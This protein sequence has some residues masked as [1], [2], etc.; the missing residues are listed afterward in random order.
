MGLFN[1]LRRFFSSDPGK[2]HDI[3]LDGR[4]NVLSLRP[5]AVRLEFSLATAHELYQK[6]RFAFIVCCSVIILG[7]AFGMYRSVTWANSAV[8]H[9][10]TCLGGWNN[11]QNA[12]GKPDVDASS[13]QSAFTDDNSAV[14]PENASSDIFCGGFIGDIPED[15]QPTKMTLTFSWITKT[16]AASQSNTIIDT[17]SGPIIISTS[18]PDVSYPA[19]D[20]SDASSTIPE[21]ASPSSDTNL[22]SDTNDTSSE[23]PVSPPEE[24]VPPP[25]PSEAAPASDQSNDSPV[26]LL[27]LLT[28]KAFAQEDATA[29]TLDDVITAVTDTDETTTPI[30]ITDATTTVVADDVITATTDTEESA[31]TTATSTPDT[32]AQIGQDF[33]NG[34]LKVSYTLDGNTWQ[35]LGIIDASDLASASFDIPIASG[36]SWKDM[37]SFQ[38]SIRSVSSLDPIPAVYL[39]GL[40]LQMV[41]AGEKVQ[42]AVLSSDKTVY[43]SSD[44]IVL[45]GA[46]A[47]SFVEIYWIDDP[48]TAPEASNVFAVQVGEDSTQVEAATLHPGNFALVDTLEPDHCGGLSLEECRQ[49][50]TFISEVDISVTP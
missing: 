26:S 6:H 12:E 44:P 17:P 47:G 32:S 48:D 28:P 35:D 13:D 36:A 46:P 50:S 9:P 20:T 25:A 29:T 18:T 33:K 38:I 22:D 41:Y 34:F 8:L 5:R 7:V 45:T 40:S 31:T 3:F 2:V 15:V 19:P 37:S 21:V 4:K 27:Y 24:S 43:G 1:K 14:L 10:S 49:V 42:S 30:I 16:D 11:P 39:D 23:Q